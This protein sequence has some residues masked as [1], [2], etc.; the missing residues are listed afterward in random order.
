MV[1]GVLAHEDFHTAKSWGVASSTA[2]ERW[3]KM[4]KIIV[5]VVS[6]CDKEPYPC[7]RL[8][9]SQMDASYVRHSAPE[10]ILR[11]IRFI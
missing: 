8:G 6:T 10:A 11:A 4:N 5:Q 3:L 7:S 2:A 9:I 1:V